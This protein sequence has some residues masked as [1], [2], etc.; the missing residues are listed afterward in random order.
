MKKH[1]IIVFIAFLG[2]GPIF[3]DSQEK[4]KYEIVFSQTADNIEDQY[5]IIRNSD[6]KKL[7]D[8]S[9]ELKRTCAELNRKIKSYDECQFLRDNHIAITAIISSMATAYVAYAYIKIKQR[10]ESLFDSCPLCGI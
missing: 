10:A 7:D 8:D 9:K 6:L 3:C 2:T 4:I 5:S 1:T